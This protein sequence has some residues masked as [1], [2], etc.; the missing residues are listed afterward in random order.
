MNSSIHRL[1]KRICLIGCGNVGSRH[2]QAIA[3]LPYDVQIDVVEP[4]SE[5]KKIAISRLGEIEFDEKK[6]H[7]S[8]Y[9]DINELEKPGDVTVVAT[10]SFSRAELLKNLLEKGH[11]R[12]LIEK[13]VCQS[14]EEYE[15]LIAKFRE[16]KAKGWVNTNP[17]C[18][19]AYRKLKQFFED[20][21]VIHFSVTASNVS[22]LATNSIHYLDLFSYFTND[23]DVKLNG[24]FL[25]NEL[26][27]NKR[28]TN[29]VEF[30]GTIVGSVK[31]GSTFS[32]TFLPAMKLPTIVNIIGIDKHI[33]IDESNGK[34]FDLINPENK[35]F[36]FSYEHASSLTTKIIKEILEN[37]SCQ[38]TNLQ[39]SF[40]L[41]REIFRI[42]N[43]HI[44]KITNKETS[45][46]PIT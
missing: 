29:F 9:S 4:Q 14:N 36:S 6:H 28:G 20:S 45:V 30:G 16:F 25:F 3:K 39:D 41:H 23:Y 18:F 2:L 32:L 22:A 11:S 21:Q 43:N 12:F 33:M 42:F 27:P 26:F 7:I 15:M 17:R 34:L 8:W 35:D 19:K 44:K 46:C 10:T 40:S 38:L 24:D 1:T 13:F 37:D 31:N 5:S